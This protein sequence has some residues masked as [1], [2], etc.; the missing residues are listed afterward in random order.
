MLLNV[1]RLW[2]QLLTLALLLTSLILLGSLRVLFVCNVPGMSTVKY[3]SWHPFVAN[4]PAF[5]VVSADVVCPWWLWHLCCCWLRSIAYWCWC[6]YYC[7]HPCCCLCTCCCCLSMMLLV[8][9]LPMLTLVAAVSAVACVPSLDA[10]PLL[11]TSFFCY[12]VF[13]KF[14]WSLM[15]QLSLFRI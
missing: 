4:N 10:S 7:L 14:W 6:P 5:S 8:R 3:S 13:H 12:R 9:L 1:C 11:L 15:F 2:H